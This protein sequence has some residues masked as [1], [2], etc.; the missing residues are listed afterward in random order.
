LLAGLIPARAN[1][2]LWTLE[3]VTFS[4]GATASG[5]FT[6]DA[7][8][9]IYSQTFSLSVTAGNAPAFTYTGADAILGGVSTQPQAF[10]EAYPRSFDFTLTSALT[11]AGGI[12]P[13]LADPDLSFD[14]VGLD[15]CIPSEQRGV[16]GGEV[17]AGSAAPE[18]GTFPLLGIGGVA[19]FIAARSR[20]SRQLAA[21]TSH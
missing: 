21:R 17:V 11:D 4:D 15:A 16:T 6:Y 2:I 20:R 12:V 14:C 19:L 9:G 3:G 1:P 18:P 10:D 13:L 8:T 7:D 5:F